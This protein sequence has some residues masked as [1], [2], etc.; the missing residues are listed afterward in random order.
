MRSELCKYLEI[1]AITNK[2]L[3]TAKNEL[4]NVKCELSPQNM[5]KHYDFMSKLFK[6]IMTD[7]YI[8]TSEVANLKSKLD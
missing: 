6:H 7:L 8:N 2:E 4:D 3:E 1:D 5:N